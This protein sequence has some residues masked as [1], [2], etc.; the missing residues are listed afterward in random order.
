[1]R[2]I[3]CHHENFILIIVFFF[4]PP[5]ILGCCFCYKGKLIIIYYIIK[6]K[7]PPAPRTQASTRAE[8]KRVVVSAAVAVV[9][10]L[11]TPCFAAPDK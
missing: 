8:G 1:M 10:K 6:H 11:N 9:S 5:L 7:Y 2:T 3:L 4:I